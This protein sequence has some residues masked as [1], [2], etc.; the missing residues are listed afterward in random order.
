METLGKL[1]V[2]L[3]VCG[4]AFWAGMSMNGRREAQEAAHQRAVLSR[5]VDQEVE[6]F[7]WR[8]EARSARPAPSAPRPAP[9]PAGSQRKGQDEG[10]TPH[11]VPP[12]PEPRSVRLPC[13]P[14]PV[15][16]EG[17]A[18]YYDVRAD[19]GAC[20]HLRHGR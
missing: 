10:G 20:A 5:Y 7:L 8:Q 15:T 19:E 9:K 16:C 1:V 12:D 6:A 4:A 17:P 3:L 13:R 18:C 2:L 11:G 14:V